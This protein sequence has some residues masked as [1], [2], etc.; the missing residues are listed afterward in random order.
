MKVKRYESIFMEKL[1]D[2][3]PGSKEMRAVEDEAAFLNL[4]P[5][6][7]TGSNGK[8]V[9]ASGYILLYCQCCI[10]V[11][12]C[13]SSISHH[14]QRSQRFLLCNLAIKQ[15]GPNDWG[16]LYL[17]L[18]ILLKKCRTDNL[19]KASGSEANYDKFEYLHT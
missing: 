11:L 2:D 10:A 16:F 15:N 8:M 6:L 1:R 13:R 5:L 3:L 7:F 17:L 19:E 12:S 18:D 9:Q 4:T 14:M